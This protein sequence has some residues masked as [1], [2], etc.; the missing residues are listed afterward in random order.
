MVIIIVVVT[1]GIF[2]I[3]DYLLRLILKNAERHRV[4][5]KRA[6]AL[7]MGLKLEYTDEA[8]SLKRVEVEKPK[9]RILAVD[10]ERVVLDSFRKI[11]VIAGY[12]IDTVETG[13]EALGLVRKNDYDFVF[14]DL[15]MP[16][17]D[18]LDVTKSVKH[19]RPDIDVVMIT[20]HATVETAVDAMRFG[21]ED[22]VEKPFSADE[23]VE[24]VDKIQIKR[25]TRLQREKPPEVM[26]AGSKAD[27]TNA[28]GAISVPGG[29]FVSDEHVWARIEPTGNVRIGLD[30]FANRTLG[31]PA[32]IEM[33][34]EDQVVKQ[35]EV[36]F[37][38]TKGSTKIFF[39]S[40]VSGTV[41][42]VNSSLPMNLDLPQVSAFDKG[43]VCR[44]EPTQLRADLAHLRIGVEAMDWYR[45]RIQAVHSATRA[46]S[47]EN[48]E[49]SDGTWKIF[50]D[51][52][53]EG[54]NS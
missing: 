15:K 35:G 33:P 1:V 25:E 24:F 14:T 44:I 19:L 4:L 51:V 22:H 10:D 17:M 37:G 31:T 36:L 41:T 5:K 8:P 11:L 46:A 47:K 3:V 23:L 50:K 38:L 6:E 16:E 9:A 40:P 39:H 48:G 12:S 26:L 54:N 29:V 34:L 42:R 2:A 30:E 7:D 21:A 28:A 43:W 32:D 52:C 49:A 18:G 53:L 27:A 13:K 45:D 20:G